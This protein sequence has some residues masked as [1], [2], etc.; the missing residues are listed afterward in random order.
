MNAGT[1]LF[2]FSRISGHERAGSVKDVLCVAWL[3]EDLL[4]FSTVEQVGSLA[5][6]INFT[7]GEVFHWSLLWVTGRGLMSFKVVVEV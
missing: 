6:C 2:R 3:T 1:I 4:L 5:A 7:E